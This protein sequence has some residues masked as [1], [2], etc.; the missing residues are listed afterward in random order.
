MRSGGLTAANWAVITE[1]IAIL[2]P[3]KLATDRLQG[4]GKAGRFGALYEVIPLFEMLISDYKTRLLPYES[5]GYEYEGAPEDYIAINLRAALNKAT[6]YY[7][8]LLDS[9]AYYAAIILHPRYMNYCDRSWG[10]ESHKLK[11]LHKKFE[12]IWEPYKPVVATVPTTT[13]HCTASVLDN[14][15]NSILDDDDDYNEAEDEYKEWKKEPKWSAAEYEHSHAPNPVQYWISREK[16]Y[17]HLSQFA[18]DMMT[19]PASS[20]EC[21]R[22]F[23]ELG[24][25]LEPK[26]R[27]IGSQLV[28]ALQCIKAWHRAGFLFLTEVDFDEKL[29]DEKIQQI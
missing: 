9:P 12:R 27:K 10:R 11:G 17:P 26:R 20:C 25:L 19:I 6:D 2:Q 21:E 3:L 24:D 7:N 15:I 13:I 5:V 4:R 29:S 14:A 18:I 28:A 23:S 1:Y 22:L 8:K 16:K